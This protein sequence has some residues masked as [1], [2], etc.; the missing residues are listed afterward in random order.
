MRTSRVEPLKRSPAVPRR[1]ETATRET[2]RTIAGQLAAIVGV[3]HLGLGTYYVVGA[4]GAAVA[5][6]LRVLLWAVAGAV[7]L[8]GVALAAVGWGRRPLYGLGLAV[9][10]LLLAGH[11]LWPVVEGGSFYLGPVPSA[12]LADPLGY[13]HAQVFGVRSVVKLAVATELALVSVLVVL[14]SE[15]EPR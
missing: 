1:V 8:G 12:S 9:T 14:L 5:G 4:S 15:D 6:D 10:G 3:V 11:L 13:A 7:L 2:M